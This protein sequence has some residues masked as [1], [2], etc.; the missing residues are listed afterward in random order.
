MTICPHYQ[1]QNCPTK[2]LIDMLRF[3]LI[4]LE[5]VNSG[6]VRLLAWHNLKIIEQQYIVQL[7]FS[8]FVLQNG[9]KLNVEKIECRIRSRVIILHIRRQ[10]SAKIQSER[11]SFSRLL[12]SVF[13]TL[14]VH[15]TN[16]FVIRVMN[17]YIKKDLRYN[18]CLWIIIHKQF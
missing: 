4:R 7:S 17:Y 14:P 11:T 16:K 18:D 12:F 10:P 15:L 6:K 8:P 13:S 3:G 5:W 9:E 2:H 1:F